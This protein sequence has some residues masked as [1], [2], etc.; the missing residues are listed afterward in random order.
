MPTGPGI[1]KS[2]AVAILSLQKLG[3]NPARFATS[4]SSAYGFRLIFSPHIGTRIHKKVV[5]IKY[6][7]T[8]DTTY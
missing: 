1:L 7:T 2:T 8:N 4:L 6:K 3:D 5:I